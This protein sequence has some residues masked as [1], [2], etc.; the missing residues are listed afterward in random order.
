[1]DAGAD[2]YGMQKYIVLLG[3]CLLVI[4]FLA[5]IM[6]GS[7]AILTDAME[8]IV[9]VVAGFIGLYALYISA[10]PRDEDHPYGHGRIEYISA[11]IEGAMICFAG[12]LILFEAVGSIISPSNVSEQL[13]IGI[14]LIAVAAVLNF[15][16]G[17]VAVRK[18]KKNRSEALVASGKHLRTDTISSAGIIIGLAVMFSLDHLGYDVAWLDGA[19]AFLFGLII[20]YTGVKVLKSSF[21]GIMDR[22]DNTLLNEVVEC[23]NED[24]HEHW[25]DIHN[26]RIEKNG[27]MLHMDMHVTFPY[28]ITVREQYGEMQEVKDSIKERFGNYVELSM[29]GE[30]CRPICC[31]ICAMD[32]PERKHGFEGLVT[33]TAENLARDAQ[34]GSYSEISDPQDDEK[35]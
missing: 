7:V 28:M 21:D 4:K 24:R 26:L 25:I 32:C 30:P 1:M 22:V 34:H 33:W 11:S 3:V 13:D 10:K 19:I 29:T 17:T 18:G 35:T 2:S 8:S 23:L 14:V 16:A 12:L 6:T 5:W 27:G 9:N 20:L 15:I 31:H